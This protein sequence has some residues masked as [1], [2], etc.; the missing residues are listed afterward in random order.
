MVGTRVCTLHCS[1]NLQWSQTTWPA[2]WGLC[3]L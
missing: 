1:V 2:Q 3:T